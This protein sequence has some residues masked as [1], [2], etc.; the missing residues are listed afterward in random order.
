MIARS[1]IGTRRAGYVAA[2]QEIEQPGDVVLACGLVHGGPP[3]ISGAGA[4]HT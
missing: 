1:S 3:P 4:D 2:A